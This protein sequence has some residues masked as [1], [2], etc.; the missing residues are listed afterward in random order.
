MVEFAALVERVQRCRV[1]PRMEGRRRIL[2]DAKGR[3]RARVMLVGT[4]HIWNDRLLA[5]TYHP[6]PRVWNQPERRKALL[7]QWDRLLM[8]ASATARR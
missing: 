4:A 8:P 3:L 5:A 7:Q 1:C 6:G 2:G